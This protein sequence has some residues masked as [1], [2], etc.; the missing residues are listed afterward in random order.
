MELKVTFNAVHRARAMLAAY[1]D[2][3]MIA[4]SQANG[5]GEPKF[6]DKSKF[7]A[8]GFTASDRGEH[9]TPPKSSSSSL[10]LQSNLTDLAAIL[11]VGQTE[12]TLWKHENQIRKQLDL[13]P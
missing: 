13:K 6:Y 1:L 10:A 7:E 8:C 12:V 4:R 2:K 11:N 5:S 9:E 3:G